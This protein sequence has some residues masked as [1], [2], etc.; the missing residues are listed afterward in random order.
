M[1]KFTLGLK[2]SVDVNAQPGIQDALSQLP[3]TPVQFAEKQDKTHE[4][5]HLLRK[6]RTEMK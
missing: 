5:G 3:Q 4:Q 6:A 2:K 1:A